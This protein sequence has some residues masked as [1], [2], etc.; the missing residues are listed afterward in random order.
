ML[1]EQK[2]KY[3][4][5][6]E[7]YIIMEGNKQEI[8]QICNMSDGGKESK[9]EKE[10]QVETEGKSHS[11]KDRKEEWREHQKQKTKQRALFCFLVA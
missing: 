1:G 9:G 3:H 6:S 5:S 11:N 7:A 4:W 10:E 8:N 2:E